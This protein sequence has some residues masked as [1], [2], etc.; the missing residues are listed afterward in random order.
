MSECVNP[1]MEVSSDN[2]W[3]KLIMELCHGQIVKIVTPSGLLT[4]LGSVFDMG[5]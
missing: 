4:N 3:R 2:H 5:K 1:G